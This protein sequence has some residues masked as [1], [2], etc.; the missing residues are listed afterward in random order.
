MKFNKKPTTL[1]QQVALLK[2]RGVE[3]DNEQATEILSKVN[4]YRF[5]GYGLHFEEFDE[6]S[7]AR[8]DK[9]LPETTFNRI[10]NL[11]LWDERLKS[12][13]QRYLGVFEVL[14]R[15]VLN[16]TMVTETQDPF[17]FLDK[18]M[19]TPFIDLVSLKQEC[20]E[21]LDRACE[22][23]DLAAIHFKNTYSE[24]EIPP[25]WI[26]AEFL[27]FGKWSKLFGALKFANHVKKVASKLNAPPDDIISWIRTLVIL[28]NRCAHHGRLWEY[29]FKIKPSK[30]PKMQRMNLGNDSV[31]T[32]I[33]ILH[34]LLSAEPL[35]QQEMK[36]SFNELISNCPEKFEV[37]LGLPE[38]FRL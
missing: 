3:I 31:G 23:N 16:Y 35:I 17:W 19:F 4:Y 20:I 26:L 37:P 36:N 24:S 12:L 7:G 14:F 15:S 10:Y 9:F 27:S 32:L 2:S 11:Y 33:Y 13:L 5:C 29:Q 6:E 22:T 18:K 34:D 28:R 21:A 1:E 8:L 30:T 25:C 38:G